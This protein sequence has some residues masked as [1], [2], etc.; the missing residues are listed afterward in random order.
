MF[1][2]PSHSG[3]HEGI[4][5]D[6]AAFAGERAIEM[7]IPQ[8]VDGIDNGVDTPFDQAEALAADAWG[9]QRCWFLANGSSQGNRMAIV[10]AAGLGVGATIVA[11]RSAH[12]SLLDG[13]ILSGLMPRFIDPSIDQSL[14]INHGLTPEQLSAEITA[15]EESGDRVCAA[16]VISPSYFGAVA[17]IR[18]LSEVAHAHGIPLIVDAAWG[19]HFG[20]HPRLPAFPTAQGADM[21]VTS[22]HKMG[23]SLSQSAMLHLSEGPFAEKLEPLLERAHR[24]T[25]TT[26]ASSLLLGSLDIARRALMTREDLIERSINLATQLSDWLRAHP[27]LSLASDS[28]RSF[29]DIVE[30]DPLRVSVDVS[31]LGITGYEVR[32][33]L[34]QEFGIFVEIATIRVVVAFFGPGKD[35][36]TARLQTALDTIVES[37]PRPEA[38]RTDT[39]VRD[40]L[41]LPQPGE[42]R[43]SPRDA[44]FAPSEVVSF[45]HAVG[46]VSTDS[47]AAYPPGIPNVTPGETIRQDLIDFLRSVAASPIGYVR[48]ALDASVSA[49]RVVKDPLGDPE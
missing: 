33:R 4:T 7:D 3:T 1:M 29:E 34:A 14:G 8:L 11:Q 19:A 28:F 37:A 21:V 35:L 41:Q 38:G 2:V 15:A 45:E 5:E 9:A 26:S 24:L 23:G 18:G 6:L 40:M 12:S 27:T 13:L 16:Y 49:F 20:F 25:Q 31:A 17:D 10:A 47:L 22:T 46:R 44:Y 42:R 30:V 43:M 48:G 36:D 32:S 39:A